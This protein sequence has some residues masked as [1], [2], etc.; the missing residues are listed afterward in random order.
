MKPR[1]KIRMSRLP[2]IT[3]SGNH[4]SWNIWNIGDIGYIE[5][6]VNIDMYQTSLVIV[7]GN[8]IIFCGLD[9]VEV[10]ED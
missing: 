5:G 8:K 4:I 1:T 7:L 9:A 2:I 3:E 6:V 10:I